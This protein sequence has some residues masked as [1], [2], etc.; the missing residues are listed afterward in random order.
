[1]KEHLEFYPKEHVHYVDKDKKDALWDKIW[2]RIG[3]TGPDMRCWFQSQCIRYYK[4]TADMCKTGSD[5]GKSRNIQ[6]TERAKWVPREFQF[7]DGHIMRKASTE[8]AGFLC[9]SA[10]V[11]SHG[12]V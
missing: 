4:L 12:E 7:L 9:S 6:M 11:R 2:E 8:T 10:N 5:A 1:M 3:R